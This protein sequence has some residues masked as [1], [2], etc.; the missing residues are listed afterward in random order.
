MLIIGILGS[1]FIPDCYAF[2]LG[3]SLW[4]D[5]VVSL[6]PFQQ[7]LESSTSLF[8]LYATE[9]SMVS[10]RMGKKG[11]A[12]FKVIVPSFV[13]VCFVLAVAP[14]AAAVAHLGNDIR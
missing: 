9:A 3:S 5:R 11:V 6:H 13:G 4:W 10:H 7:T 8:A 14:C 1:I 2:T 12:T